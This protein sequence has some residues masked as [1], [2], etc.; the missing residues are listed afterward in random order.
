MWKE[1]KIFS[2][3]SRGLHSELLCDWSVSSSVSYSSGKWKDSVKQKMGSGGC[4]IGHDVCACNSRVMWRLSLVLKARASWCLP[5]HNKN[6]QAL[7]PS[8]PKNLKKATQMSLKYSPYNALLLYIISLEGRYIFCCTLV[9]CGWSPCTGNFTCLLSQKNSSKGCKSHRSPI[10]L[11]N[12]SVVVTSCIL[13]VATTDRLMG[14]KRWHQLFLFI[15]VQNCKTCV[16]SVPRQDST[17]VSWIHD[18]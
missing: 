18:T 6:L 14:Q 9:V 3:S 2:L 1:S 11:E 8:S 12:K 5:L 16:H 13:P 7:H 15:L 10:Y 17:S 4:D